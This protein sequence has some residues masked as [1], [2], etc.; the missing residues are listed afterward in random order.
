MS[1]PAVPAA[2]LELTAAQFRRIAALLRERAG[3]TLAEGSQKL[4]ISRLSKHLR[5]LG[6]RGFDP[7]LALVTGAA[8][9]G[10]LEQMINALTTNTTRFFRE[11]GHFELMASRILPRLIDRARAGGRVRLWSAACSSG[12]EPYSIAATVLAAFP[13][14]AR[15]DLRILATDINGLMLARAEA[16]LYEARTV[17][18]LAPDARAMLFEPGERDGRV[19]IRPAL[20]ELVTFRYLNFV[21][22]WPVSGPFDAIFCR[23]AAIY[24]DAATQQALWA[25]LERV[26]DEDGLLFIGHSERIGP[27]LA[28]RLELFAPTAFRRPRARIPA[29]P[30]SKECQDVP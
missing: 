28:H 30:S 27:G 24:M 2:E 6:H 11:P 20:R 25:G 3:I 8:G 29:T 16:A 12:E 22:D 15:F 19:A 10:E 13:D 1:A 26:L 23:N 7:Y 5:R 18:D 17:R 14:A 21:E 4:V 9:A